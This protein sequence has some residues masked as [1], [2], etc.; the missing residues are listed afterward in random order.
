MLATHTPIVKDLVLIGGGHSQLAVLKQFGMKPIPGLRI[1]LITRDL[2]TPYSGMLPGYIAGHYQYDQ[3]HIDLRK[4]ANFAGTRIYHSEVSGLDLDSGQVV[5]L[6]RPPVNFDVVSINIGSRPNTFNIPGSDE[7]ALSVKPIDSFLHRWEGLSQ[8]MLDNEQPFRLMVVGG[9]AGGVEMALASQHRLH[10]VLAGA[11][12]KK[13]QLSLQ[14]LTDS[15][16][17]L[18]GHNAGTVRRFEQILKSRNIEVLAGHAVTRVR[19]GAV[20][21][22]NGQTIPYDSLLWATSASAQAWPGKSGLEVDDKG[23]I[24][25]N[26]ALQSNSHPHVFVAGDIARLNKPS[27]P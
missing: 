6:N 19:K 1:T 4:L 24:R 12:R 27:T 14:L 22:E 20:E 25:V 9:G 5:C 16:T 23:F 13:Q 21:C 11:G 3:T 10:Q 17:V 8:Y 26:D 2:H 7:Y 15:K 18:S